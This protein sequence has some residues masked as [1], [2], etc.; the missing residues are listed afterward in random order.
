MIRGENLIK[1]SLTAFLLICLTNISLFACTD[2]QIKAEDGSVLVARTNEFSIPANSNIVFEPAGKSFLSKTPDGKKGL[3]WKSLYGFIALNGMGLDE[4]FID[5]MNEAGLSVGML[6]FVDSKYETIDKESEGMALSN[7]DLCSW[8]L[9]NFATVEELKKELPNI[10]VWLESIPEIGEPLPLHVSVHDATGKSI[11]IE[12]ING[13]KKVYDNPIGVMTNMPEFPWQ[14]TNLRTFVNS[15]PFN[16][17]AKNFSG[18]TTGPFGQGSGWLGIPGDWTPPSRFVRIAYA[19]NSASPVKDTR[20]AL[21]LAGHII[22][23]V[24]IPLGVIKEKGKN[25]TA[26]SEYTQWTVFKDLTNKI[27]YFKT[28]DNANLRFIDLKKLLLYKTGD[29]RVISITVG[30]GPEELTSKLIYY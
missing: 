22:N 4:K 11:V 20:E 18:I 16:P 14:V 29:L 1:V 9:G 6:L 2:F 25:G 24:D 5:G 15:N 26:L 17:D 12:F 27:M 10:R 28:Y 21:N 3:S 13:E 7:L 19:L 30:N 8:I 23:I